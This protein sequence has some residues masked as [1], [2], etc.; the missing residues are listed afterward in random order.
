MMNWHAIVDVI[1]RVKVFSS[2]APFQ[3]SLNDFAMSHVY[4]KENY[5]QKRS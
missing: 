2:D 1:V 5:Y 3:S 4:P